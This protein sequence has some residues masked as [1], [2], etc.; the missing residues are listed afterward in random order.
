VNPR[1]TPKEI[2][3]LFLWLSPVALAVG[4]LVALAG[5]AHADG[6]T[7]DDVHAALVGQPEQVICIVRLESTFQPYAVNR[8]SGARG[9]VQIVPG[10]SADQHFRARGYTDPFD[11]Y[12][13]IPFLVDEILAGWGAQWVAY[14]S[15][16]HDLG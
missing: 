10:L 6:W 14:W 15:C 11:P 8:S 16:P 2:L 5:R 3:L 4:V 9:P 13:A 7:S 12:Q 1:L